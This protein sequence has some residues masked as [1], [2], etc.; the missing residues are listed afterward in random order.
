[1]GLTGLF[2]GSI[3][4]VCVTHSPRV[5]AHGAVPSA[6][7]FPLQVAA[8][9]SRRGALANPERLAG[10]LQDDLGRPNARS[11]LRDFEPARGSGIL[12]SL[13]ANPLPATLGAREAP[14]VSSGSPRGE[15][16]EGDGSAAARSYAAREPCAP[17][18][19]GCGGRSAA[20]IGAGGRAPLLTTDVARLPG[21]RSAA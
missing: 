15:R 18:S 17:F 7:S 6:P 8:R 11:S 5:V 13:S 16:G 12:R 1:M 10:A 4:P 21:R 14:A 9:R 3:L 19:Q 20:G 2:L